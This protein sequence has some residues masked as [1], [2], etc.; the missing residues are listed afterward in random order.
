MSDTTPHSHHSD[1]ARADDAPPTDAVSDEV[2]EAA[3]TAEDSGE[4]ATEKIAD[5]PTD[6]PAQTHP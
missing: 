1:D 3:A 6:L 4:A 5:G 2:K